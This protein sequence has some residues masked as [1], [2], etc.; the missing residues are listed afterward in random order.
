M[1]TPIIGLVVQ[2][3]ATIPPE[4]IKIEIQTSD[5]NHRW[6]EWIPASQQAQF[7]PANSMY[8]GQP[9]KD[10][11]RPRFLR[12]RAFL[13]PPQNGCLV[14]LNIVWAYGSSETIR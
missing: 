5:D 8:R 9:I 1:S 6:S 12:Y 2:W 4:G 11:G 13:S 14:M 3:L 7:D 10:L